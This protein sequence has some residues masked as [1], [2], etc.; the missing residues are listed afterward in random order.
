MSGA[1][2]PVVGDLVFDVGMHDGEDTDYYLAKGFRVVGFEANP[3]LARRCRT[4]FRR[5]VEEKSLTIVEGAISDLDT[6]EV[7]LFLPTRSDGVDMS[8]MGS[9]DLEWLGKLGVSGRM[10]AVAVPA[11]DFSLCLSQF[12]VPWYM[13]IDIE[14]ADRLCLRALLGFS[15]RPQWLSIEAERGGLGAARAELD[16]LEKLGYRRFLPVPQGKRG[17]SVRTQTLA[18]E[19]LRYEFEWTASGP[20]GE[21]LEGRWRSRRALEGLYLGAF[22]HQKALKRLRRTPR[23]RR[24][25]WRLY[26]RFPR[27]FG[28][29]YYD[30]HAGL[31]PCD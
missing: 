13:K 27:I 26:K 1:E 19:P 9:T 17:R 22:L 12:G 20:F 30:T 5:A 18:G 10:E 2:A 11:V 7:E 14:G 29:E 16:L 3:E 4:R 25:W 23:G 31:S 15:G 6:A 21:D 28:G 8:A 24:I